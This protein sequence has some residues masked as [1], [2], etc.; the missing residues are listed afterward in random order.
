[1]WVHT[2]PWCRE[3]K[4]GGKAFV[5]SIKGWNQ[6]SR[7]ADTNTEAKGVASELAMSSCDVMRPPATVPGLLEAGHHLFTHTSSWLAP[8]H[9]SL[10]SLFWSEESP[11]WCQPTCPTAQRRSV[12]DDLCLMAAPVLI[13]AVRHWFSCLHRSLQ[14]QELVHWGTYRRPYGGAAPRHDT[15][16]PSVITQTASFRIYSSDRVCRAIT[17]QRPRY[18][19]TYQSSF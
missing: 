6:G 9:E 11:Q 3:S 12:A 4:F 17:M 15:S 14:S 18:K 7:P 8:R 5:F 16:L 2:E 1:M 19:Q 13:S 10:D